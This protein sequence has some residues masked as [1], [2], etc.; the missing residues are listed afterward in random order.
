[1]DIKII[2]RLIGVKFFADFPLP[3]Q[4]QYSGLLIGNNYNFYAIYMAIMVFLFF[5]FFFD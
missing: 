1:M 2:S 4:L 5:F 3:N